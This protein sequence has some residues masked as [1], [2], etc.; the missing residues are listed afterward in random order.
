MI[1]KQDALTVS[2]IGKGLL[3]AG[4]SETYPDRR[5]NGEVADVYSPSGNSVLTIRDKISEKVEN[6]APN[7]VLNLTDSKLTVSEVAQFIQRTPVDGLKSLI[8][9]KDGK[10]TVIKK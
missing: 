5:I 7:I 6:Q 2:G 10:V 9:I 8:L 4:W 1:L 3:E